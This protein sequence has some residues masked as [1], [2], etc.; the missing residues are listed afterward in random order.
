MSNHLVIDFLRPWDDEDVKAIRA[1]K[2]GSTQRTPGTKIT[3]L[4]D[5]PSTAQ[6]RAN[7]LTIAKAR[8][9]S[10]KAVT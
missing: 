1:L 5:R 6:E 2:L 3:I 4:L 9:P 10:V 8:V 7:L